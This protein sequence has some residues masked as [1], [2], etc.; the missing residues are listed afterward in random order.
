MISLAA[1]S[2]NRQLGPEEFA[3]EERYISLALA[4]STSWIRYNIHYVIFFTISLTRLSLPRIL[5]S[6]QILH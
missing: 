4:I 5:K 2:G 3:R 1:L 6:L